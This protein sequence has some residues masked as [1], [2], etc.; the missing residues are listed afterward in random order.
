MLKKYK[1]PVLAAVL[2]ILGSCKKYLDINTNPVTPQVPKAEFLLA[3]MIA[4]M[5][6]GTS[7]DYKVL[8]KITQNMVGVST[9]N[10]S[11][12][13]EKHTYVS[14]SDVSGVIWR[15]V[16]VDLG[17]NLEDMIDD[18][19]QNKKYEYVGIGYAM[20]AWAY[21]IATDYYGPVILDSTFVP[22][23]LSFAYSD[24][25]AVYQKVR[26]WAQLSLNYLDK[27]SPVDYSNQLASVS[28]DNI[29]SGDKV[30]WKKFVYGLLA[31]QYSHLVNKSGFASSLAD[32]VVKYADLS[33]TSPG[34]DATIFFSASGASDSNPNG[35][36]YGNLL[37]PY[38]SYYGRPTPA[39]LNYLTGGMRGI[40]VFD[41]TASIDPR[42]TRMLTPSTSGVYVAS[43]P[44]KGSTTTSPIVLGTF[45]S[46]ANSYNGRYLFADAARYPLMSYSQLQ[47]AKAEALF[48]KGNKADAYTAYKNGIK[49]HMDFCNLYGR[50]SKTPDPAISDAEITAYMNSS[51]VA[52]NS[53]ALTLADIMGQ[54]YIAQW[55]W[56]GVEQW[57]DL[58]K[59]HYRADVF[60][61]F[62]QLTATDL[63]TANNGKYAYRFRPRYNSEYIWNVP[64]LEKWGALDAN[65]MTKELWFSKSED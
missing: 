21:Q 50:A 16:Y 36:A 30:K 47:F 39:I 12:A 27:K 29:Y 32:S 38:T 1:V 17:R 19:I 6:I 37:S 7:Q 63:A 44:T 20:K 51:E 46:G 15:M 11:L 3:P 49:A 40:A 24:Q 18:G 35:P 31:L 62:T 8:F 45:N 2:L 5:A 48:I 54:K 60:R 52:Q 55:G 28:G 23:K 65:Y 53:G 41:T 14:A 61:T 25:P 9:D 43:T 56:A 13:W 33:F 4:Q 59:Y 26:E 34:D 64:E 42:L 58:R 57:C 22:G 10:S